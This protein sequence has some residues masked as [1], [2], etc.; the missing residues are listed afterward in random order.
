MFSVNRKLTS[1]EVEILAFNKTTNYSTG[2][3]DGYLQSL[4]SVKTN[5][6]SQAGYRMRGQRREKRN[7]KK[8]QGETIMKDKLWKSKRKY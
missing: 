6:S 7:I 1:V 2:F 5:Q 3:I 4:A 8:T